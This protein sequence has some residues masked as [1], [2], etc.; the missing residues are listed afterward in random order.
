MATLVQRTMT[1][2]TTSA[3][4]GGRGT[5]GTNDAKYHILI[6]ANTQKQTNERTRTLQCLL[7]RWPVQC[8]NSLARG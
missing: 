1:T 7:G 3:T 2:M 4:D 8:E 5:T 6:G